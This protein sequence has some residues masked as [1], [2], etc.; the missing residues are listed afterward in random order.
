MQISILYVSCIYVFLLS[1]FVYISICCNCFFDMY[2]LEINQN[3]KILRAFYENKI[4]IICLREKWSTKK[5]PCKQWFYFNG[6][7]VFHACF[8]CGYKVL[9]NSALRK[10]TF[11][12]E[13][14]RK[15]CLSTKYDNI[16][17]A[18]ADQCCLENV[19]TFFDRDKMLSFLF[20]CYPCQ[21]EL[22][23]YVINKNFNLID[24]S[25]VLK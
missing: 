5:D 13:T 8:P 4:N 20:F 19:N 17:S 21:H 18:P 23:S 16:Y 25:Y 7:I 22:S 3:P 14:L 10:R 11:V 24:K 15:H 2:L 6:E 12:W 1:P 9:C